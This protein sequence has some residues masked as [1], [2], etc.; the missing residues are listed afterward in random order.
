MRFKKAK[1]R[2]LHFGL[3]NPMQHYRLGAEWLDDCEEE[4]ALGVLA[5]ARLNI[6]QQCA[7]VVKR[8]KRWSEGLQRCRIPSCPP[9]QLE[10]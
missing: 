4:R 5:D 10:S 9:Y 2:V 8:A 7:Q 3:N 1:C 6:N